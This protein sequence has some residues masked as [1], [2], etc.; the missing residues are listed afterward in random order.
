MRGD[1][2]RSE[3]LFSYVA[4]EHRVPADHPVRALRTMTDTALAS[5]SPRFAKLYSAMGRPS[6]PP[7]QLLR[8][9]LLQVLYSVRSERLLI[10]QLE[11]NLLFR[12]FVGLGM[13]EP[14]WNHSTFSKNRDRLLEGEIA[15]AFFD[16]VLAAARA[17]RLL[18]DEHFTVDGTLIEAWASHKSVQPKDGPPTGTGT[19]NPDVDFKRQPRSNATHASTTDPDARLAKHGPGQPARLAYAAHVCM[20]NA[21]GL[22]VDTLVTAAEGRAEVDA[23]LIMAER[24]PGGRGVTV[25][26]DRKYD[27]RR[28][29]TELRH[30]GITPHVAQWPTTTNRRSAIDRRTTRHVGYAISQR[31]RKAVEE[32]F[33]WWKT[34]GG[35]RKLRHRGGP[36]VMWVVTFTA[37]VYNLMRMRTLAATPV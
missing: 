32:I 28:F 19:G 1:D 7:E 2:E 24:L 23:A 33:G 37:A 30:M 13:D 34:V 27:E 5:L 15:Q 9:L 14:V 35:L 26:A 20:D 25:G 6:I 10:E 17:N 29:V 3:F 12:W 36:R 21:H 18:S 11:Y 16:A 8:A 22:V 31:K 4:P